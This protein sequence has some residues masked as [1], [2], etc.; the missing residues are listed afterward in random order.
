MAGKY[1]TGKSFLLNRVILNKRASGFGVGPT[2]NPCTKGLWVWSECLEGRHNGEKMRI[3][4]VDSEGIGAFDEDVNHDTKIFL[5]ALL[6]CSTF[7][8]NSMNTIDENAINSLSLIINLSKEL[9]V[10]KSEMLGE[11]DPEDIQ[12]FFPSF[13]WVVRDFSLRLIDSYGNTINQKQYLESALQPQKGSSDAV[14]QKNRIRRMIQLFFKDRDCFTMVR[15][16]E[17]ERELQ[18][19][20]QMNDEQFRPEF[21]QQLH[22][23]RSRIMKK[24]K[25]KVLNGRV[26]TGEMLYELCIAY[27]EAIN[28]GSVPNIQSAWSYVCQNECQRTITACIASYEERIRDPHDKAKDKL[29]LSILKTAHKSLVEQCAYQFRRDA[30]GGL[31]G[32]SGQ[33]MIQEL[34][35]K[36]RNMIDEKYKDIKRD[37]VRLCKV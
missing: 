2:I 5:L 31:D 35:F 34:E 8:F 32:A 13:L 24:A 25:P 14:E 12:K 19:L 20:Q 3:L 17:N 36:L 22:T 9:Q 7:I 1:R 37:F 30:L 11:S 16:V 4:V 27:T 15:P 26:L 29:D 6:L 18:N 21:Q 10:K 23:L 33:D 28:T